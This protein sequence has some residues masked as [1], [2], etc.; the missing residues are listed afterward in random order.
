MTTK[1]TLTMDED[2][3]LIAKHYAKRHRSSLSKIVEAF[4]SSLRNKYK[5]EELT[6][7]VKELSGVIHIPTRYNHK[8]DYADYL[9]KK[10][11]S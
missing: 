4:F 6:P 5:Q 11:S 9:A 3:I 1:L 2:A 10:Y 8:K 7:I